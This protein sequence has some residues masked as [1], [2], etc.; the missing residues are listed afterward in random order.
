MNKHAVTCFGVGSAKTSISRE[1]SI[2]ECSKKYN[3]K[4]EVFLDFLVI[5]ELIHYLLEG[6]EIVREVL[7]D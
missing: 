5:R 1:P 4:E 3:R 6:V 7:D 2:G